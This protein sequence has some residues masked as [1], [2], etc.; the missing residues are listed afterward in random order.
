MPTYMST[1]AICN[2]DEQVLTYADGNI[3]SNAVVLYPPE[4]LK[5]KVKTE[6]QLR[7]LGL[8]TP[9]GLPP[10]IAELGVIFRIPDEVAKRALVLLLTGI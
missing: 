3:D 10:M 8:H 6:K 5:R 7:E 1:G 9:T 4:V 2:P